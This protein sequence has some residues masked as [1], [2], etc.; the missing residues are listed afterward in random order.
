MRTCL[1]LTIA[2]CLVA[3]SLNART[4]AATGISDLAWMAGTWTGEQDGV[5]MEESWLAPKGNAL[6]GLHRDVKEQRMIS[7]EFLRIEAAAD[8]ITYWASPRGKPATPFKMIELKDKRVTFENVEHDFPQRIIYWLAN[9]DELHA[10][11]EGKLKGE[12]ASEEWS[13]RR[14]GK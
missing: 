3:A 14:K 1:L 11:I 10:R 13:W 12:A 8:G 4:S 6:L 7:F 5:E 2:A 9:D